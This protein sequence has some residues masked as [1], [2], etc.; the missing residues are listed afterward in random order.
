MTHIDDLEPDVIHRADHYE[1][2]KA[3]D[4]VTVVGRPRSTY[5]F[6]RHVVNVTRGDEYIHLL[7]V[8][9]RNAFGKSYTIS[10]DLVVP[11]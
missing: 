7:G 11:D 9:P 4:S 1:G 3:G 10:P 8:T 6:L 5:K 2:I